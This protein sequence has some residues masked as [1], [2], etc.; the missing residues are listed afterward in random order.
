M[1]EEVKTM[2]EGITH[3]PFLFSCLIATDAKKCP[4]CEN[5]EPR[6]C[7]DITISNGNFIQNTKCYFDGTIPQVLSV[8]PS[9]TTC[10]NPVYCDQNL[11]Q[12]VKDALYHENDRTCNACFNSK[13]REQIEKS[14]E[15]E[16]SIYEDTLCNIFF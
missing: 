12:H 2:Q 3:I 15:F 6:Y 5:L 4:Y 7:C 16:N 10:N 14:I 13:T 8:T 11:P 1:E 9:F